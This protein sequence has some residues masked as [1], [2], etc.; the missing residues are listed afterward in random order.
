MKYIRI[1]LL[2]YVLLCA[3]FFAYQQN[4]LFSPK[5]LEASHIYSFSG[6][7]RFAA[8][9]IVFDADTKIELV[10]FLPADS[11]AASRGVVLFFHGNKDNVEHYSRYAPYFTRHGY[12]VWMPDYPGYGKS[13]GELTEDILYQIAEQVYKM[14]RVNFEAN[15]VVIYGKSLGTGIAAQLAA[16][17]P[18]AHLL[19][20]T[21][22]YN[23]T[24]LARSYAPI[25]PVG[26]LLKYQLPAYLHLPLAK[27]PVTMLV[28]G[29]DEVIR[30]ENTLKLLPL[31][32][33]GDSCLVL[34]GARH[35]S[36]PD[37]PQYHKAIARICR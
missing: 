31:L 11:N 23:M 20:E 8:L 16:G 1:L 14:A 2:C 19:L 3:L 32:R 25:L 24:L 13:T 35:N 30:P 27:A 33:A 5:A 12:E 36:I 17:H 26:L 34:P 15:R 10:K 28:A 29:H 7:Q 22:Y 37:Y 9:P 21:P 18:A 4:L 6:V